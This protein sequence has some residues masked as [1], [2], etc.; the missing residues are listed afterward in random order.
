MSKKEYLTYDGVHKLKEHLCR[1][2]GREIPF[3]AK[4]IKGI[5]RTNGEIIISIDFQFDM[6]CYE[7]LMVSCINRCI[8]KDR[9]E[10]SYL[11]GIKDMATD[12]VK[13]FKVYLKINSTYFQTITD[14]TLDKLRS[15]L[16]S[17]IVQTS[18]DLLLDEIPSSLVLKDMGDYCRVGNLY[19]YDYSTGKVIFID[20]D[21]IDLPAIKRIKILEYTE[22]LLKYLGDKGYSFKSLKLCFDYSNAHFLFKQNTLDQEYI[23]LDDLNESVLNA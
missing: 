8:P 14:P 3:K 18:R 17:Y 21:S 20:K 6:N 4:S 13:K 11:H 19:S 22:D 7:G 15:Q 12:N 1:G 10:F 16:Y 23:L 9:I 5:L 2:I